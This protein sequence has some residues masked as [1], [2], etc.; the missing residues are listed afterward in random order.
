MA[1]QAT[2]L[3]LKLQYPHMTDPINRFV[4]GQAEAVLPVIPEDLV[5]HAI[6]FTRLQFMAWAT[7][8]PITEI[9]SVT[10]DNDLVTTYVHHAVMSSM[11]QGD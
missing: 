9:L 10:M 8:G 6:E 2:Y 1:L 3:E 7:V 4:N 5:F 11:V